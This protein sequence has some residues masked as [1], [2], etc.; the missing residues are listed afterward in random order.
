MC[1]L[2][3][4]TASFV[5]STSLGEWLKREMRNA[6]NLNDY[7]ATSDCGL[8]QLLKTLTRFFDFDPYDHMAEATCEHGKRSRI[9]F[10]IC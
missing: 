3:Q 10:D 5:W 9:T 4:V 8:D 7:L 6:S 2:G 1:S